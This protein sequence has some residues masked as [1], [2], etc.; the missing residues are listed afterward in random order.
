MEKIMNKWFEKFSEVADKVV[1]VV[2]EV[3]QQTVK[4]YQEKG[5]DGIVD[6]TSKIL[7]KTTSKVEEVSHVVNDKTQEYIKNL[8]TSNKD[9][10]KEVKK[11]LGDDTIS[12]KIASGLA[13][14][15]NTTQT[16]VEDLTD[17]TKR[18][19]HNFLDGS[20]KNSKYI[21]PKERLAILN[22]TP[23][24]FVLEHIIK[25]EK[26][27][28]NNWKGPNNTDYLILKDAWYH[29]DTQSSGK[30]AVSFLS[31]HL[32][33]EINIK[34]TAEENKEFIKQAC[35]ILQSYQVQIN[36][37]ST[38][39]PS[40]EDNHNISSKKEA[41]N[42]KA[43]NPKIIDKSSSLKKT[44]SRKPP[45][46]SKDTSLNEHKL[47]TPIVEKNKTQVKR[48]KSVPTPPVETIV[49]TKHKPKR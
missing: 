30:S 39:K 41:I 46:Q 9:I 15:V 44:S 18:A 42:D 34:P 21:S 23:L 1:N 32:A 33:Q 19:Y 6:S 25:A 43:K 12:S 5:M 16:M 10:I 28:D 40:V 35:D 38:S 13:A 37:Q 26:K 2:A 11:N 17:V 8:N 47:E 27:S 45:L 7:S 22:A 48:K 36:V 20:G 3:T 31:F 14:T 29:P 24:E 49:T 4:T